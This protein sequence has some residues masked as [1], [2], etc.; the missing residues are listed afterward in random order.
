MSH[1]YAQP[2]FGSYRNITVS[3]LAHAE[4][5]RLIT[6]PAPTFTLNYE[7]AAVERI[8]A[9]SGGQPYL[10]QLI[11]SEAVD[12]LNHELFDLNQ[13]RALRITLADIETVLGNDFFRQGTVYFDGVW[14][15]TRDKPTAQ[16]LLRALAQRDAPW[17]ESDLRTANLYDEEALTWAE[18]HDV[19][20]QIDGGWSF[21]VPLMRRFVGERRS[22]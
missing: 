15:Q 8:I 11:C 10:I 21:C 20:R 19:L 4:A 16:P 6:N 17:T 3:Y 13:E 2:F 9:E 18:R 5:W 12:Q 22:S 14:T 7:R 1:D